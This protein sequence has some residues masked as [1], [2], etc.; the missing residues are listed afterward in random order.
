MLDCRK[1]AYFTLGGR[2]TLVQVYLVNIPLNYLS[3]LRVLVGVAKL[4]EH[5]MCKFFWVMDSE[6]MKDH[7][8]E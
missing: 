7:L 3:L 8:V 4:F 1:G 6:D 5:I 2:I